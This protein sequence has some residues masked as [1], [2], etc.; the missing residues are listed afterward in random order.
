MY[1]KIIPVKSSILWNVTP[2]SPVEI[3]ERFEKTN[4]LH[5]QGKR[6]KKPERSKG[7]LPLSEVKSNIDASEVRI[8]KTCESQ[9]SVTISVIFLITLRA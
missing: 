7:Q 3:H 4:C 5:V 2:C 8:W 1:R 9:S 6:R